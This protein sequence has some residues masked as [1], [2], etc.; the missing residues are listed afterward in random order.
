M[1]EPQ[2]VTVG[3]LRLEDIEVRLPDLVCDLVVHRALQ[4]RPRIRA[5]TDTTDD[6]LAVLG[7]GNWPLEI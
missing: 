3:L 4:H 7:G 1:P 5:V 6:G 2:A